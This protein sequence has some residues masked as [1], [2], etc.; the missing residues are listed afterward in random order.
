MG[1]HLYSHLAKHYEVR[2]FSRSN[3]F[4]IK[5]P[6][7][8]EKILEEAQDCDVFINLVH[9]Y[10]HQ[11]DILLELFQ[12]WENHDK[13]IINIS[14]SVVDSTGWGMDRFD[15]IEYKNQ[16]QNLENLARTLANKSH[17]PEIINYRISEI[18]LN[19][20]TQRISKLIDEKIHKK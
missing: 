9:N 8:R 10:Y 5:N 17:R 20:D 12:K 2:G 7:H 18:D 6:Q 4:D 1:Q 19:T 11:S 15:L 14:S 13:L 3:G 16:K